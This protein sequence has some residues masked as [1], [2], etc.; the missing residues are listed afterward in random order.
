MWGAAPMTALK[1]HC[2]I[3]SIEK[4]VH[5]LV[6]S[7]DKEVFFKEFRQASPAR[8]FSRCVMLGCSRPWSNRGLDRGT[9]LEGRLDRILALPHD[10]VGQSDRGEV[11]QPRRQIHFHE[12]GIDT[13][14]A[15]GVGL[16]DQ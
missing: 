10:I 2:D 5:L 12:D 15:A 9:V 6:V 1:A 7:P 8:L 16:G 11:W 14:E 13:K 3:R 4:S